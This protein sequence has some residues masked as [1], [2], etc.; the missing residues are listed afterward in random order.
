[1]IYTY[2]AVFTPKQPGF[3]VRFPDLKDCFTSGDNIQE[4]SMM[5]KDCLGIYLVHLIEQGISPPEPTNI[6]GMKEEGFVSMIITD[7]DEYDTQMR[8]ALFGT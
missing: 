1:M 6:N 7:T 3:S 4:A 8:E 5:A 2:P